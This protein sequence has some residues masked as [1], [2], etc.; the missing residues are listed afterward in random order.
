VYKRYEIKL[1]LDTYQHAPTLALCLS[2][3]KA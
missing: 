3:S 1:I 2:T